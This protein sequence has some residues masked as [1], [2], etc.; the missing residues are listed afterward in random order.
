MLVAVMEDWIDM[1]KA[2]WGLSAFGLVGSGRAEGSA[3][4]ADQT[5]L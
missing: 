1:V 2:N 5:H 3:L 4:T